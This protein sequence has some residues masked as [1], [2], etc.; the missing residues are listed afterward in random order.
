MM[1]LRPRVRANRLLKDLLQLITE[2][3]LQFSIS[4]GT[5]VNNN[6]TTVTTQKAEDVEIADS[7]TIS[8]N[9]T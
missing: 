1:L 8:T 9:C 2:A 4:L 6:V 3:S 7:Q 5:L